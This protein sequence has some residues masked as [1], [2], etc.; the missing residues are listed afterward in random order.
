MSMNQGA[1]VSQ[2][3]TSARRRT[4][5]KLWGRLDANSGRVTKG[6]WVE[7]ALRRLNVA[8]CNDFLFQT[9]LHAFCRAAGKHPTRGP[10]VPH[11]IEE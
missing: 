4:A 10:P 2:R 1:V 5:G 8:L 7:G 3:D 6:A 11:T 9:I